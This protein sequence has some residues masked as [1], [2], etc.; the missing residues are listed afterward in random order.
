MLHLTTEP[1]KAAENPPPKHRVA[2][3]LHEIFRL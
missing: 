1:A 2:A 3:R